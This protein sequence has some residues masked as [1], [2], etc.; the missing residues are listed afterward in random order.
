[1]R[2]SN[3]RIR[4]AIPGENKHLNQQQFGQHA[5][6]F[7]TSAVHA[8]GHSLA[9]L[10][11]LIDPQP[12][13]KTLDIATGAGH[14]A[15]ALAPKVKHVIASD[16]TLPM[17]AAAR[18]HVNEKD[19]HNIYYC[20]AD[21]ERLPFPSATFDCVTCRIA[22]HHF[23]DV[24]A[25]VREAGRVLRVGGILAVADNIVSGEAKVAR[26][27]N[28]I[29]TFRDP[30]HHWAYSLDDWETFVFSAGL[31]TTH[32]EVFEKETN[33]DE[34]AARLAIT[35]DDLTRLQVLIMQTPLR[36]REWIVPRRIGG[37]ILFTITEAIIVSVK[38]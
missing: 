7:V 34:W 3:R 36:A 35:G 30:S 4:L 15:L 21:A 8:K 5:A 19:A 6:N 14:M 32:S 27:S 28:I 33:V 13:W 11:D 31:R 37:R 23:A 22:P 1:V 25:F 26:V 24:A 9:R 12:H 10:I 2:Q 18:Q 38:D 17:L 29:D 20:E 16:L